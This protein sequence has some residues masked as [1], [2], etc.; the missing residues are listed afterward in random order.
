MAQSPFHELIAL[1]RGRRSGTGDDGSPQAQR[2][3]WQEFWVLL[4][5]VLAVIG[6]VSGKGLL[7]A[8]GATGML[9]VATS[10]LWNQVALREVYLK[11]DLPQ[12]RAFVDEE[13]PI[14]LSVTN[15]KPVPLG[16]MHIQ[17]RL[18][19]AVDVLDAKS[20]VRQ[21][22]TYQILEQFTAISWYEKV[23][24]SYTIKCSK[25]GYYRFGPAI[26]DSGDIFGF[27]QSRMV[28]RD[29]DHLLVYPKVV[30]MQEMGIPAFRA[31][32]ESRSYVP[33]HEDLSLPSTLREYR[34]GDPANRVAWRA[35]ARAQRLQVRTFDPS[36]STAMMLVVA[37]ETTSRRWEGY[38]PERLERTI[39]AAASIASHA[40]ERQFA[41]GLFSNGAPVESTRTMRI[42]P[43]RSP[44]Q[45]PQIMEALATIRPVVLRPM[46][47]FLAES[48]RS[49]P[50][51]ST[52]VLAAGFLQPELVDSMQ[53]LKQAGHPVVVVYVGDDEPPTMPDGIV[54]YNLS[55]YFMRM[56][57][58][59][60]YRPA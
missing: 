10:W 40:F 54:L 21:E 32:G 6:L 39:T 15:G 37:V 27:Y 48:A 2:A 42:D 52:V 38:I 59:I 53:T 22:G 46:T 3:F 7:V 56:E 36:A 17:D 29:A 23:N 16:W 14:T 25:R 58:D 50:L 28:T 60:G 49:F 45:L 30:P 12:R 4:F 31:L 33:L 13:V 43:S 51:G 18:P 35:S 5:I 20:N 26:I 9:I 11:R 24:W 19:L 41:V 1:L 34:R 8:F 55:G 47:G 57:R 44:E